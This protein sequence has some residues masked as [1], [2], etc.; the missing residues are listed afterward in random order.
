M[1]EVASGFEEPLAGGIA[2]LGRVVR[3]GDTVRR[4]GSAFTDAIFALF[5]HLHASGFDGAPHP[6]GRDDR[7]RE[8]L[9]FIE[10]DVPIPPFPAW[11]MTEKALASVARLQ[12]RFH[13]A[14]APFDVSR[15]AWSDELADIQD[16]SVIG[17]NDICPE[18]VVFRDGE[19]VAFLDWDFAAPGRRL[20]DVAA[21]MSMWGPVHDPLDPVPGMEGLEPFGRARV[22]ADAYGLD[23]SERA[24]IP[25]VFV[26]R[27]SISLVERRAAKGEQAFVEMLERQGGAGR[28]E[29]RRRWLAD[30]IDALRAAM[31]EM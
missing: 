10:G 23:A 15:F 30:N 12:R 4:P 16:G 14:A 26:D 2:N 29:R 28:A 6:L 22:I 18:N 20:W 11:S 7:G 5:E 8:V 31:V 25:E 19:A 13:E 9:S 24:E 1:T 17:H 21:V 3:V 27:L